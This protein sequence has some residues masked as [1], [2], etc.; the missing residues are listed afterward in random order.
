MTRPQRFGLWMRW[1]LR[2]A[3]R[4]WVQVI[5]IGLLLALGVGMYS[6]MSSMAGWRTASADASFAALRYHDLRVSLVSGSYVDA[7]RLSGALARIPDRRLVSAARERLVVPIQVDASH[8]GQTIIVPGRI[9][10]APVN[11]SVDKLAT[12]TGRSLRA[13][14]AG[15]PIVEL[16]R[17]FAKHY[18]LSAAGSLRLGGGAAV[19]YVGQ[20]LAPEYF[21]VTAPG[22]DFG[23]EANFAVLFAPLETAQRLSGQHGRVNELVLRVYGG[24]GT[25]VR[26]QAELDRSL[27]AALPGVGFTF[28]TGS[29]E[30]AHRLLYKDAEGDQQMMDIFAAL[31]LGA[32]AF[33]A[34]NLISRTIEAQ[35]REIGIGMALGVRP[36]VLAR[37][38]LL[39]GGQVALMGVVLGVPAGFAANAWLRSVMQSFFPLPVVKTPM[40]VGVFIQGAALGLAVSLLATVIPLR[41]ALSVT[42]VEAISVGARA[43]KSSGLAWMVRGVRLPGGSLANMPLRNILRTPRRTIM[44]VLGIAAVVAITL[45]LAGVIDSFNTTLDA[46]RAEALGTSQQRLTVDLAAPQP[47]DAPAVRAILDSH[48][49]GG[50]QPSL[51]LPSSLAAHG[52]RL[53]AFLEM[54]PRDR[55][56]W[57]PTLRTG[58]LP[59]GRTGL[60]IAA[61]AAE[62]LHVRVGDRLTVRYPAPTGPRSY[63]LESAVLPVTGINTSPLRFVA[64]SNQPA[65]TAMRLSGLVNRVSVVPAAGDNA[66][67]VKRALLAMPNVTAVQGAAA[68]TDAVDQTM[69]QFTEV[70]IITVAIAIVMALL[71]AYNAAAINAE[72]RTRETATMFAYG[73]RPGSVIRGSM[74]EALLVGALA[75]IVGIAGGYV[76]LRWIIDVSMRSTMPDLG[77]LISISAITYGLAALAG[78]MSVSLAPLLTLRRLRRTDVPSAL[79]VVE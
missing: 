2:D 79:R 51:R 42:P 14:D 63:R 73:I 12:V 45:A 17:N 68:M 46:S 34:F 3:R 33:A 21:I 1:A 31:L 37:R 26:L 30:A 32:A 28:T 71:I 61:R 65:A 7:G 8:G 56:L 41:R 69:A 24:S 4:R 74:F 62:D 44:T 22:A 64:Y 43:A 75:T 9:V 27:R 20:A 36:R 16:E 60:V 77:V 29:Q 47:L 55:P 18:S 59:Q 72:E 57:R 6:A 23:A 11:S 48:V 50:A 58:S 67:D 70:L 25:L 10:G 49:I 40:Q 15:R 35:R 52:R 19:R 78:I 13:A 53:D 38:P 76:I 5:S 39:L 54:V 66:A